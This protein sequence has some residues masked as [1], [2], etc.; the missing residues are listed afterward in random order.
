LRPQGDKKK[1]GLRATEERGPSLA[2]RVTEKGGPFATL[3]ASAEGDKKR[4]FAGAQGDR[5][6]RVTKERPQGDKSGVQGYVE[7]LIRLR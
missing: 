3:R 7:K 4:P 6:E 2:L 1:K 5:K